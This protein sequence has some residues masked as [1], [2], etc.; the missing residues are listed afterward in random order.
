[1]PWAIVY[2]EEIQTHDPVGRWGRVVMN[3]SFGAD[4]EGSDFRGE[5]KQLPSTCLKRT[6][7]L[8][9]YE[10]ADFKGAAP[11]GQAPDRMRASD[12]ARGSSVASG[13]AEL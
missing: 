9:P 2:L 8:M 3:L 12:G 5:Q 6:L 11:A 10:A 13:R 7:R 4:H 1:M